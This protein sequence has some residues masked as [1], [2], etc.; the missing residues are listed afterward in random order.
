MQKDGFRLDK[1]VL[2]DKDG[3]QVEF[4]IVTNSGNKYR[5]RMATMIQQDL[6]KIGMKVNVVTLDFPS[7][8]ERMTESFNYE[9]ALLGLTN[10]DLDP[11]A[12][13]TVWLSSGDNHQWNPRQKSPETSWEAEIDR[14][15]REQASAVD[16]PVRKAAFDRVQEIVADQAPFIYL[17]NKNA[18]SAISTALQGE[19][20]V[21]LRPQTYWNI[22]RL[23]LKAE[24]AKTRQ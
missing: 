11:N 24:I 15:M 7:L 22:E 4:S 13:M 21:V 14:L 23:T 18:L 8:I 20:P 16:F 6:G 12:Q 1:G 2:R 5:E 17:V 3:H 9:A 10:V 19:V